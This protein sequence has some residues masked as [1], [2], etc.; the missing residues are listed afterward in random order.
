MSGYGRG[1]R[2]GACLA[3]VV[4]GVAISGC[5]GSDDS[6]RRQAVA[7][8]VLLDGQRLEHGSIVF[9]PEKRQAKDDG[10]IPAGGDIVNGRF[11]IPRQKGLTPGVY[12]VM[13]FSEKKNQHGEKAD[14]T[15]SHAKAEPSV[16]EKI[17][18]KFNSQTELELDFKEGIKDLKFE[19]ESK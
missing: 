8:T 9:V 4:P 13:I 17:P 12:K 5:S 14:G 2:I 10:S 11:S 16:E 7:G 3:L 18:A 19:I 15:Q 1:F 6:W